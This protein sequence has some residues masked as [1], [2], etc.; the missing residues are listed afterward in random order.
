MCDVH[1]WGLSYEGVSGTP[2]LEWSE[3]KNKT[4]R[5]GKE[6]RGRIND[7]TGQTVKNKNKTTTQNVN[8]CKSCCRPQL[9]LTRNSEPP[10]HNPETQILQVCTVITFDKSSLFTRAAIFLYS[11]DSARGTVMDKWHINSF[12]CGI[13]CSIVKNQTK[14][15]A[16]LQSECIFVML[17]R[18]IVNEDGEIR[19]MP[20]ACAGSRAA[21]LFLSRVCPSG[22]A[23]GGRGMLLA[24]S[25]QS[26]A[27]GVFSQVEA[28]HG[29]GAGPMWPRLMCWCGKETEG[30]GVGECVIWCPP[31]WA[32]GRIDEVADLR[33]LTMSSWRRRS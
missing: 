24:L 17:S 12:Q 9:T 31:P 25:S 30:R 29:Q 19:A 5:V 22:G 4:L 16:V 7:S 15:T 20:A 8:N 11:K 28:A 33:V 6:S 32:A 14:G 13:W 23:E 2:S 26:E 1:V 10:G 18:H 3:N 27:T 21:S